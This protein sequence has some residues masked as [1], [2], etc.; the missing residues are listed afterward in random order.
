MQKVKRCCCAK[1]I[2]FK[3]KGKHMSRKTVDVAKLMAQEQMTREK[4]KRKEEKQNQSNKTLWQSFY[5]ITNNVCDNETTLQ[6]RVLIA[7]EFLEVYQANALCVRVFV[8]V[9]RCSF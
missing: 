2:I 3:V 8:C 5:N 7:N 9:F 6:T 1:D 4:G